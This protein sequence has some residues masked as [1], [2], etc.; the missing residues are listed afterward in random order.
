MAALRL[1]IVACLFMCSLSGA[2]VLRHR[3]PPAVQISWLTEYETAI[4]EVIS[5]VLES[6][7]I[8]VPSEASSYPNSAGN[9][10]G[11]HLSFLN[12]EN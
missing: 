2:A 4:D 12:M 6:I 11:I 9:L 5:I 3:Q 1:K 8:E 10:T 7:T